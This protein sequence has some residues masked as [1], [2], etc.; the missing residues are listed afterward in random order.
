MT[1][2]IIAQIIFIATSSLQFQINFVTLYFQV[3]NV[4]FIC[5]EKDYNIPSSG[6]CGQSANARSVVR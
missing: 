4:C 5:L 3:L 6:C 2:W 1:E